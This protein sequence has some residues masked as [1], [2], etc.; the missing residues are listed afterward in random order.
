[1]EANEDV[2]GDP[3]EAKGND[4]DTPNMSNSGNNSADNSNKSADNGNKSADEVKI[5]KI[6]CYIYILIAIRH[7]LRPR[8]LVKLATCKLSLFTCCLP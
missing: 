3:T 4:S 6:Y 5:P 8:I 7:F 2:H 1:M